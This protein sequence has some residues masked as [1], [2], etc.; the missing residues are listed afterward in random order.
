MMSVGVRTALHR[1]QIRDLRRNHA[2][3]RVQLSGVTRAQLAVRVS[4]DGVQLVRNRHKVGVAIAALYAA[5][6]EVL[7]HLGGLD[8]VRGVA[9]R[10]L[11]VSVV[12]QHK[13]AVVHVQNDGVIVAA[14]HA[15][16]LHL[17][18]N[19]ERG[20]DV[21]RGFVSDL[22]VPVVSGGVELVAKRAIVGR[23]RVVGLRRV[24]LHDSLSGDNNLHGKV[25]LGVGAVAYLALATAPT[26]VRP[27]VLRDEIG[28]L[29]TRGDELDP[30][31]RH[32][33]NRAV[34]AGRGVGAELAFAVVT[35][36]E[37]LAVHGENH[38]VIV[39]A[40]HVLHSLVGEHLY[41]RGH[42]RGV[43]VTDLT[44]VVVPHSVQ[45][46]VRGDEHSVAIAGGHLHNVVFVQH[47]NRTLGLIG[48]GAIAQ[49]AVVVESQSVD[50]VVHHVL[51][52]EVRVERVRQVEPSHLVHREHAR[53]HG[54][55]GR[56]RNGG[57]RFQRQAVG[58]RGGLHTDN[59]RI[60][61]DALV[62]NNRGALLVRDYGDVHAVVGDLL[63]AR[64]EIRHVVA[65][66]ARRGTVHR[67]LKLHGGFALI[68]AAAR[69]V[70]IRDARVTHAHVVHRDAFAYALTTGHVHELDVHVHSTQRFDGHFVGRGVVRLRRFEGH[71]HVGHVA[72]GVE[73]IE[74]VRN[75]QQFVVHAHHN[76]HLVTRGD[77]EVHHQPLAVEQTNGVVDA[78][79]GIVIG[80]V[81]ISVV[82]VVNV[83][84]VVDVYRHQ[85]HIEI[86]I[87]QNRVAFRGG[88]SGEIGGDRL[89][90]EVGPQLPSGE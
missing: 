52:V 35:G 36:H 51:V 65:H 63:R 62:A 90:F 82:Y 59:E 32:R 22:T 9:R 78:E 55:S 40:H 44:F 31:T 8:H 2:R 88:V 48:G 29:V 57:V 58:Q 26:R 27:I 6:V 15:L 37:H 70:N 73:S 41:R 39:P 14:R 47:L 46:V 84:Q 45:L 18:R 13:H 79:L 53:V 60:D 21:G 20:V 11:I 56:E 19:F 67:K 75:L 34:H 54:V 30:V 24:Y 80:G 3:D 68:E 71:A 72:H 87:V 17:H 89:R 76:V 69:D 85:H 86:G 43:S 42:G 28:V 23:N 83:E 64:H 77:G 81:Y 10:Q 38:G 25:S 61:D 5:H 49:L 74:V 1:D 4:A 66:D 7:R 16:H 33:L 12:T 50:R